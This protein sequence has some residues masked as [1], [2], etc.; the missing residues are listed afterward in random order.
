[1]KGFEDLVEKYTIGMDN[2]KYRNGQMNLIYSVGGGL[3]AKV[4]RYLGDLEF[5]TE[6]G[7]HE[8]KIARKLEKEGYLVP[9]IKGVFKIYDK[10]K[11]IFVPGFVNE[12]RKGDVVLKAVPKIYYNE[13]IEKKERLLENLE[14]DGF[15]YGDVNEGN[16]LCDLNTKEI[17][18]IDFND[19][20]YYS[21]KDKILNPRR[22]F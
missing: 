22:I 14:S 11:G 19:W 4:S 20:E 12:D 15:L 13:F 21:K 5:A 17:R 8:E 1:M 7:S 18:L 6:L 2:L 16:F 9:K 3:V 10:D